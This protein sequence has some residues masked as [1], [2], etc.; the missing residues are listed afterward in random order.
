MKAKVD[1]IYQQEVKYKIGMLSNMFM[2]VEMN[3]NIYV[4]MKKHVAKRMQ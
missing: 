4:V 3:W 1:S 2:K